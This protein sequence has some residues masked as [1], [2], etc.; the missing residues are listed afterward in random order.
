LVRIPARKRPSVST[1]RRGRAGRRGSGN[2]RALITPPAGP[3]PRGAGAMAALLQSG[4]RPTL[5]S[6]PVARRPARGV[7][8][9][10]PCGP[11]WTDRFRLQPF[12]VRR[13]STAGWTN[14]CA[15]AWPRW[16]DCT[17]CTRTSIGPKWSAAWRPGTARL[18]PPHRMPRSTRYGHRIGL[19]RRFA[20]RN[21]GSQRLISGAAFGCP[22]HLNASSAPLGGTGRVDYNLWQIGM[23]SA[24][25]KK[26]Q[27]LRDNG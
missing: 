20:R 18:G 10:A 16:C 21:P 11:R 24:F 26:I 25:W 7:Y 2:R 8:R 3:E 23:S 12:R 4:R 15:A 6:P 5:R 13:L 9:L 22:A 19:S 1:P 17:K 27:K 14:P